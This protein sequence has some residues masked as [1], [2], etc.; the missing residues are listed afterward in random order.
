MW[1]FIV[2]YK[3]AILIVIVVIII[4]IV[5]YN[6]NKNKKATPSSVPG[7]S[8]WTNTGAVASGGGGGLSSTK[9]QEQ[10]VFPL[11]KGSVGKQ[12]GA[13]QKFIN[14]VPSSNKLTVDCDF[15]NATESEVLRGIGKKEVDLGTYK[16]Y[17]IWKFE[18]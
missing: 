12:V 11:K 1:D 7:S 17:N 5:I 4:I 18:S 14:A 15:G 3:W 2:K 9:C 13:L 6:Y 8:E 16:S 10:S